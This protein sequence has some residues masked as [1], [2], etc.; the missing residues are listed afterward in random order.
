MKDELTAILHILDDMGVRYRWHSWL[1]APNAHMFATYFVPQTRY[2]GSDE[3]AE[4]YDY[5][6][7][8][9]LWYRDQMDSADFS[10]EENFEQAVRGA[11]RFTKSCGFDSEHMLFYSQYNFQFKEFF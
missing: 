2:D 3:R 9:T 11:A 10:A 4:Y 7:V 1:N 5:T 8:V 6:A